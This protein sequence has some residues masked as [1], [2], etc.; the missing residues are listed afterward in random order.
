MHKNENR[1]SISGRKNSKRKSI[2][3][4]VALAVFVAAFFCPKTTRA[5]DN[6]A[7]EVVSFSMTP[8]EVDTSGQ[9]QTITATMEV[10]DSGVGFCPYS[11]YA[12]CSGYQSGN[13]SHANAELVPLIGTSTQQKAFSSWTKVSGNENDGV[14]QSSVTLPKDSKVGIWEIGN[15]I[16]IEVHDKLGNSRIYSNDH[17]WAD[18]NGSDYLESIPNITRTIANIA[19][20]DSVRIEKAWT[21]SS[22]KAS[23]TFP[24]NTL[25]TKNDGGIFAFYQM[26]NEEASIGDLTV[27]GLTG[28]AAGTIKLGIPGLNLSFD[29]PVTVA[30]NVGAQYNGVTLT[31]KSLS[32]GAAS[33]ASE[34]TCKVS[35][36]V[37]QFSVSH[38]TYFAARSSKNLQGKL[39]L[40]VSV[41]KRVK[42]SSVRLTGKTG[43]Y[44]TVTITVNGQLM[45]TLT[46][47]K[48]GKFAYR[49]PLQLGANTVIVQASN[50]SGTKTI[51]K[52]I[53]R[54]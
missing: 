5:E 26:V 40:K 2:F 39:S 29:K 37:C 44:L 38:A 16:A 42:K 34:T 33:W 4:V 14:W 21:F 1:Q 50:G 9:D 11:D 17:S 12:N 31:I 25:V 19:T 7:P 18:G 48:K 35:S 43:K 22:S 8:T 13:N 46:A 10:T 28:Y 41:K 52:T 32:E 54:R 53:T 47:S 49:A 30:L 3:F 36:S 20:S 51:T 45:K 24:A 6:T 15:I 23:V 27:D